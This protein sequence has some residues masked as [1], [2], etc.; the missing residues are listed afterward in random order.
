MYKTR[1][2]NNIY[3]DKENRIHKY[4]LEIL[5]LM[6]ILDQKKKKRIN[7]LNIGLLQIARKGS[8]HQE[9]R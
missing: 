9:P 2:S 3:R 7:Y 1:K 8:G 4:S 5:V 6:L